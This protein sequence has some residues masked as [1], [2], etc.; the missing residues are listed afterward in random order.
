MYTRKKTRIPQHDNVLPRT[1]EFTSGSDMRRNY[2][3]VKIAF[4]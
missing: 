1:V 2:I 4:W 3:S